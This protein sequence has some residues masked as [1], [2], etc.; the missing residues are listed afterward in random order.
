MNT[1]DKQQRLQELLLELARPETKITGQ[2]LEQYIFRLQD[3]YE[4]DFRH[5]YS[6]VFGVITSIDADDASELARLQENIQ[7]LHT[8][9]VSWME[10]KRGHVS[11][12]FCHRLE[13]L[14]DHVNLDI[15]RINYTQEIANR[16]EEKNRK[17]GEEIKQLSEKATNMQKD[18]ITILGI[19]SSIVITFVA[20][21]VF[22]SSVLSNIDKVSIYRLTFVMLMI[23][24]LLFNLLN[25]LL[26]FIRRVN[27][28]GVPTQRKE[29]KQAGSVIAGI[30]V[31]L[32]IMLAVDLV[33]WLWYWHRFG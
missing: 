25:L 22:S 9:S 12:D 32:F 5:L 26:D 8:A 19:F 2:N 24:L 29:K 3:I 31:I 15:S 27:Q 30:N 1:L 7:T 20:G 16:M 21:M 4:A 18:Y 13:K 14:Y 11:E 17:A 6:G 23:A 33:A 28:R 10:E